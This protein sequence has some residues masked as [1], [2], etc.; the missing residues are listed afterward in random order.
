V[1]ASVGSL[2]ILAGIV[3]GLRALLS[4]EERDSVPK[5]DPVAKSDPG[6]PSP[7]QQPKKPVE[8]PFEPPAVRGDLPEAR[9]GFRFVIRNPKAGTDGR[10]DVHKTLLEALRQAGPGDQIV[11]LDDRVA[12]QL[13]LDGAQLARGITVR[14][15]LPQGKAA[16]LSPPANLDTAAPLWRLTNVEGLTLKGFTFDGEDRAETLLGVAGSCPGLKLEDVEFTRFKQ[17][18]VTLAGCS[19]EHDRPVTF[20]RVRWLSDWDGA[21]RRAVVF[22]PGPSGINQHVVIHSGRFEGQYDAVVLLDGSALDVAFTRNR[23]WTTKETGTWKGDAI[24]CRNGRVPIRLNLT[25]TGNTFCRVVNCLRFE[26][27]PEGSD[28]NRIVLRDNL[29]IGAD[30]LVAVDSPANV[31]DTR[32]RPFF[33]DLAGNVTRPGAVYCPHGLFRADLRRIDFGYLDLAP[34]DDQ[35][36]LRYSKDSPLMK[37]G[38]NGGPVGVPPTDD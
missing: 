6:K 34:K 8:R 4:K 37:A 18:A 7:V 22:E 21:S 24:S 26:A 16:L 14:S 20:H 36:F 35:K 9:P 25:V 3:L 5:G 11:I 2:L 15:G 13:A 17:Q 29:I 12:E 28:A 10:T 30:A 19:G 1:T 27:L 31:T 32:A 33:P 23:V 38:T